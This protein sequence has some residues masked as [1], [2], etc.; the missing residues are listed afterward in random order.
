MLIVHDLGLGNGFSDMKPKAQLTKKKKK[1][2]TGFH[3]NY[4]HLGNS[5]AVQ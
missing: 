4:K 3:T 5:L 1:R 2:E